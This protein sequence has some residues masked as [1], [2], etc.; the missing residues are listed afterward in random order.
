MTTRIGLIG[1]VHAASAPLAEALSVLR[2]AGAYIVA[3]WVIAQV[4]DVLCDGLGAPDWLMKAILLSLL[5]GF[6]I[7]MVIS[8]YVDITPKGVIWD[9]STEEVEALSLH[10]RRVV[11]FLI[12]A[13]LTFIIG[14]LVVNRP[15]MTC[16]GQAIKARS[17]PPVDLPVPLGFKVGQARTG[18][19]TKGGLK[20][21]VVHE[22]RRV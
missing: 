5:M 2:A 13:V 15:G 1:D 3:A 20:E 12:I 14:V 7:A 17:S 8:W 10:K 16:A 6:P 4:A 21:G 9:Y 22:Q 19:A 11:D 18:Y